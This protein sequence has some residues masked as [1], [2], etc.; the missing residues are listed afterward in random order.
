ML[1]NL[2]EILTCE[3]SSL[4]FE[5]DF[6]PGFSEFYGSEYQMDSFKLS[7]TAKN[8]FGVI[9]I[10]FS[11]KGKG[12]TPCARCAEDAEFT[13]ETEALYT[14]GRE[15]ENEIELNESNCVDI[16]AMAEE[17]LLAAMPSTVLCK[18]DCLGLCS[19]C[20]TNLN[21]TQCGCKPVKDNPFKNFN[22]KGE[23]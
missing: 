12:K 17:T 4:S 15:G 20:G 19:M 1:L 8:L 9:E 2:T 5:E 13:I 23:V 6:T 16:G 14:L 7:G 11:L 10:N 21:N 22:W 3:G 18:P